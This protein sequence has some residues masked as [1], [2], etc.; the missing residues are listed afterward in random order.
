[1]QAL[2]AGDPAALAVAV[3]NDLQ[4]AALSLRPSLAETL[5]AGQRGAGGLVSG[6]DRPSPSSPP[7]SAG[8]R[9]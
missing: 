4:D 6:R 1:M 8:R 5:R 9:R 3:R 2:R 7:M